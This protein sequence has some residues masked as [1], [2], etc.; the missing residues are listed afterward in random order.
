MLP[1]LKY[2]HTEDEVYGLKKKH[3]Y[4]AQVQTGMAVLNLP[5]CY[6]AIYCPFDKSMAI[7]EVPFDENFAGCCFSLVKNKF[8]KNMLPY[9]C[10]MFQSLMELKY[11]KYT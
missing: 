6:F 5:I 2:I 7:L 8:F 10:N 11:Y 4:Y 1:K 9:A 3:K